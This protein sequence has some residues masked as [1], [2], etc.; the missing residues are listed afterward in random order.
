MK[1]QHFNV[2]NFNSGATCHASSLNHF[3]VQNIVMYTL[4]YFFI[5]KQ[6]L[7]TNQSKIIHET[8]KI[9]ARKCDQS[10][11]RL[12]LLYSISEKCQ[13]SRLL[14]VVLFLQ[15]F[16]RRPFRYSSAANWQVFFF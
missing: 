9:Y 14:F 5:V 8:I 12:A 4:I 15:Q 3:C 6:S 1:H 11:S 13:N 16:P 2:L 7:I 10:Q